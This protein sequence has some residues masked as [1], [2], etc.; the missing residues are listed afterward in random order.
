MIRP[1]YL[2]PGD[3]AGIA[4]PSGFLREE[5]ISH[6]LDVIRS[7]GLNIRPGASLFKRNNSF[8]GNDDQ[9]VADLQEMLDDKAVK[10][11]ICARGGYG[12]ARLLKHLDFSGFREN[13]KWV[14]GC[15]DI[16]ALHSVLGILGFES[17]HSA[18][19]RGMTASKEDE[20]SLDSL[21]KALFGEAP[22]FNV[23]PNTL[24]RKGTAQGILTG[25]NLSVL[26][27]LRG[28]DFDIATSGKILFL[29]DVGEYLYHIDRMMMNLYLG[30]K[31][32]RLKGLV[33]GG[34]NKMKISGSGYRK[35]AYAIISEIVSEFH[36]PV[37]YGLESGHIRPNN[38]LI[39]GRKVKIEAS[40][41]KATIMFA[42]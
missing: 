19:P 15:S 14:A 40:S 36:Y 25:G 23:A 7:W 3:T 5:E 2:K 24:N 39:L 4:A 35:K 16:T 38:T 37:I 28:T 9:R 31:L 33:I 6:G 21:K 18:M 41:E 12:T 29:E 13:P 17:M 1:P 42:Q 22:V 8:A 26:Y 32:D 20:D 27:S 11:I 30:H 34:M 10:A